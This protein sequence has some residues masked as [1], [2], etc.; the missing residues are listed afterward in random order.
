MKENILTQGTGKIQKIFLVGSSSLL[1]SD[2]NKIYDNYEIYSFSR[3]HNEK[4]KN[5]FPLNI[6]SLEKFE[7]LILE[8]NPDLIFNFVAITDLEHCE[9]EIDQSLFINNLFS[10]KLVD[11]CLKYS[12]QYVFLS[13]DQVYYN[14]NFSEDVDLELNQKSIYAKHKRLSEIYIQT[15]LTNY[16][17]LRTNFFGYSKYKN[18]NFISYLISQNPLKL[19]NDFNFK[20]IY[21]NDLLNVINNLIKE[22]Y[23]GIF[24][25]VCDDLI[26]KYELGI[27]ILNIMDIS[28]KV[29]PIKT[30]SNFYNIRSCINLSTTKIQKICQ[31][32][33]L[34]Q[35][36]KNFELNIR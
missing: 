14:N 32:P 33:T 27:K 22:K 35:S 4:S 18:N 19:F 13:T 2:F 21:K 23:K 12:I 7:D 10:N 3:N 5:Y 34:N 29:I 28:K 26:S 8:I 30:D 36:L 25:I 16:L 6:N 15:H 20:T 1:A 31:L 9:K 17:I 24:N 11:L